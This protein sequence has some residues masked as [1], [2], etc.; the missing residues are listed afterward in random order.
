MVS[1]EKL[2]SLREYFRENL[3]RYMAEH[4]GETLFLD[5]CSV[6]NEHF[7]RSRGDANKARDD[8]YGDGMGPT[9]F[10]GTIP[11]VRL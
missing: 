1:I 7:F 11:T 6:D 3:G 9:T 2:N 10:I 5:G 4:P 8:K